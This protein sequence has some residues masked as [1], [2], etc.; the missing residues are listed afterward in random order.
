VAFRRRQQLQ[1]VRQNGDVW[2]SSLFK[3]WC[4]QPS[5]ERAQ[6]EAT[7]TQSRWQTV[8]HWWWWLLLLYYKT[9]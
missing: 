3:K 5:A 4:F 6:S 9:L 2:C 7:V 1:K 8:T